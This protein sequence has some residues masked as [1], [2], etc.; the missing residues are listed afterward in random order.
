MEKDVYSNTNN[1]TASVEIATI[2][3]STHTFN[4]HRKLVHVYSKYLTWI[5]YRFGFRGTTNAMI[6]RSVGVGRIEDF[7]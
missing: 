5:V 1:L 2:S 6:D 4:F 3:E 7:G